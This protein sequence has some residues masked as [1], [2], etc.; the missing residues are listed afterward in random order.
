MT[1]ENRFEQVDRMNRERA[2]AAAAYYQLIEQG[3]A[4][5]AAPYGQRALALAK[6]IAKIVPTLKS[7]EPGGH[8]HKGAK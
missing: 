7:T 4:T 8:R 2:K 3:K 6:E 1:T 5:E